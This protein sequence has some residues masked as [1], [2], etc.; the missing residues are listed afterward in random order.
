MSSLVDKA[1]RHHEKTEKTVRNSIT[2]LLNEQPP[3]VVKRRKGVYALSP[4][5]IQ[6]RSTPLF[7]L[8]GGIPAD[9]SQGLESGHIPTQIPDVPVGK[10]VGTLPN[11]SHRESFKEIP[12]DKGRRGSPTLG[13]AWQPIKVETVGRGSRM[14]VGLVQGD[15]IRHGSDADAEEYQGRSNAGYETN[16]GVRLSL[17][18]WQ[19]WRQS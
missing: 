6:R 18:G 14:V 10:N 16:R 8:S 15:L 12:P 4:G 3:R 1:M 7:P 2:Q 5:E 11:T 9:P 19:V 17:E 13:G